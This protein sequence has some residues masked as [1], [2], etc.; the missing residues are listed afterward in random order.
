MALF[1]AAFFHLSILLR[2]C[3]FCLL[4]RQQSTSLI[5]V[6]GEQIGPDVF[7]FL[8]WSSFL[9]TLF[10]DILFGE[11]VSL[12]LQCRLSISNAAGHLGAMQYPT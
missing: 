6:L 4:K 8:K 10:A 3:G 1:S 9:W 11:L 5:T 7:I 12:R 2:K